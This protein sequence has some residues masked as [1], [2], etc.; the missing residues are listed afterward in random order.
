MFRNYGDGLIKVDLILKL[1]DNIT[2]DNNN[3]SRFV[4][5]RVKGLRK[6]KWL[7]QEALFHDSGLDVKHVNKLENYRD[8]A[9]LETLELLPESLE[10]TYSE[11]FNFDIQADTALIQELL[12]AVARLPKDKQEK[13]LRLL[14]AYLKNRKY[15]LRLKW[16]KWYFR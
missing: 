1:E 6:H 9:R 12:V 2:E 8:T 14:L 15:H 3:L 16:L 4:V 13:K 7:T 11:F 10:L 5:D